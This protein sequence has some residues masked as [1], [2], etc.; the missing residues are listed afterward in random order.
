MVECAITLPRTKVALTFRELEHLIF[1][2]RTDIKIVDVQFDYD[3]K[4]IIFVI[5]G[6]NLPTC[7]MCELDYTP[8][9]VGLQPYWKVCFKP[10]TNTSTNKMVSNKDLS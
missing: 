10:H 5:A 7:D 8:L 3:T 4:Q 6:K 2:G 9:M 1:I